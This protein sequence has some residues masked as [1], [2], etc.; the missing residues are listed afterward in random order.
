MMKNLTMRSAKPKP[1]INKP[2]FFIMLNNFGKPIKHSKN[3]KHTSIL[4]TYTE[5][6]HKKDKKRLKFSNKL[7]KLVVVIGM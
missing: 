2:A 3:T 5:L 7:L 1:V 4:G 6:Y